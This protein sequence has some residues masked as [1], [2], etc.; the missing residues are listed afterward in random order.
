MDAPV[1]ISKVINKSSA[2]LHTDGL[3]LFSAMVEAYSNDK[4]II[5][6]FRNLNHCTTAFLNASIGK[7][8]S[9]FPNPLIVKKQL[10]ITELETD[11]LINVKIKRVIDNVIN[12]EKRDRHDQ[13]FHSSFEE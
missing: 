3:L 4:K 7:F 1:V 2:V 5:L 13:N 6:S 10:L 9:E 11:S 8:L 12:S